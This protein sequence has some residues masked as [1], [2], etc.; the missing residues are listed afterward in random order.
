MLSTQCVCPEIKE[1]CSSDFQIWYFEFNSSTLIYTS[2]SIERRLSCQVPK[3]HCGITWT[4]GQISKSYG[5]YDFI[6]FYKDETIQNKQWKI[7]TLRCPFTYLPVGLK[8]VEI[9]AS[10]CPCRLLVQRATA[11]TLNTARGWYITG[12]ICS[13]SILISFTHDARLVTTSASPCTKNAIG[14]A[15]SYSDNNS[16]FTV[17]SGFYLVNN[18]SNK[19]VISC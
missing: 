11:R 9:T 6:H 12:R 4:A 1:K 19:P 13:V 7:E 16:V 2:G 10:V 3:T 5:I 15:S 18:S 14:M 8:A 17:I